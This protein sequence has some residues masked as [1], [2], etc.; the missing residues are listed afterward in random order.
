M[1]RQV[2]LY[3]AAVIGGGDKLVYAASLGVD[4]AWYQK[5]GKLL[6]TLL[7]PCPRCNHVNVASSFVEN[8]FEWARRWHEVVRGQVSYAP[9]LIRTLYHGDR[10]DRHYHARTDILLRHDYHPR[11]DL[12]TDASGLWRWASEKPDLHLQVQNYLFERREDL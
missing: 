9:E 2:E 11:E 7:P 6:R 10:R 8:Y 4:D 12:A 3:D 5:A 1:L